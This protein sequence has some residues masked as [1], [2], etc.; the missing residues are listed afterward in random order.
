VTTPSADD[1]RPA[2]AGR[3]SASDQAPDQPP[4]QAPGQ[5]P[6][7]AP[8]QAPQTQE[9]PAPEASA[10]GTP[11]TSGTP[12]TPGT[13]G[14]PDTA[15]GAAVQAEIAASQAEAA[16]AQA[17][18]AAAEAETAFA[19]AQA[20]VTGDGAN[21]SQPL[22]RL[23]GIGKNFGPVRALIDVNLDIPAGQVTAVVGD[24]GAGKSTLIKTISGIWQPDHG[25]IIWMDHPVRLH[26]PKEASD[27]GIAT[28]YQDLALADNLDIVQNMFLGREPVKYWQLDE[29]SMEKDAKRTLAELSVVTI[30]SVR[31]PV[32]SL[33][34]G[35]RQA[36]AVARAVL[37]QARLVIL[38]EPTAALGVTQTRV[39]LDLI[40][41]LKSQGIAVIVISHNLNDVFSVADRL[42]V[43]RLG[44]VV[45]VGPKSRFDAES[46]VDLMTTG[47]SKR[48]AAVSAEPSSGELQ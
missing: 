28:V 48:L 44:H 1:A 36:V 35:Q 41:R 13:P 5:V 46:V 17:E 29:V 7:Q 38:D 20:P 39:V 18:I 45:A 26:S 11:G 40:S 24:N 16:A 3:A 23:V 2:T 25:E 43:L 31:Q 21:G 6:D 27:L 19:G 32:G 14:D 4:D 33:S 22:L 47:T 34:G 42:A 9:S 10:P 30:R 37:R 12:N 15:E 8:G